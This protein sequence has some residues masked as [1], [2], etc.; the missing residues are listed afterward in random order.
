MMK[1]CAQQSH[2]TLTTGAGGQVWLLTRV[3]TGQASQVLSAL[4]AKPKEVPAFRLM[5]APEGEGSLKG[6]S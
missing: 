5:G 3:G 4:E 2:P 1:L 6:V